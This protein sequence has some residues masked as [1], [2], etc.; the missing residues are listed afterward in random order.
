VLDPQPNIILIIAEQHRADCLSIDGH[1]VLLTPNLDAIAGA[2]V[3][4]TRAYTTCPTCIAARR[5]ILTGQ[6]PPTHGMVG[7]R[8]GIDWPDPPTTL[9]QALRDAGYQTVHVGRDMHQSPRRRRLGFDHM[10]LGDEWRTWLDRYIP[11]AGGWRGSGIMNN[12]YTACPWPHADFL[13]PTNWTIERALDILRKRDPSCPFF[14][15]VSFIAAHPPLQPPVFYFERYVRTG[16]PEPHVGDWAA[17]PPDRGLG[18]EVHNFRC[19]L[20][21]EKLLSARAGYYGLINHL[22]DQ[23]RRLL[24]PPE[25]GIDL[26]NT[27]V[28]FVSDHGEMLGDHYL[29]H[30]LRPYEGSARIPML[31]RA[32]SRFGVGPGVARDELV[33]LEDVMPTLLELAG[34]DTPDTVEGRSLVPLLRGDAEPVHSCLHIEH[35]P[36]HHTLFNGR[37]KYVWFVQD[38]AEQLFD[39]VDDPHELHELSADRPERLAHWRARMIEELKDRPEGFSDGSKLIPGRPYEPILPHALPERETPR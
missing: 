37:E 13:H 2:G 10:I 17:P 23:I 16:V 4:F 34:V 20:E 12:D 9:P 38:G 28:M 19:Q 11:D 33:C 31:I 36:M 35:A 26:D 29:W 14:L 5:S 21:G 7:Y 8:D 15:N 22:D 3:R 18:L 39:V 25:S 32:P 24:Y 6:F 1:P 30:K 27:I